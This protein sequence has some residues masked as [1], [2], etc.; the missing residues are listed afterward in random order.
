M[1]YVY[2]LRP[3]GQAGPIKIGFTSDVKKR[4]SDYARWSPQPLEVAAAIPGDQRLER[5]FHTAF[6]DQRLHHEW[7]DASDDLASAI[8]QISRGAFDVAAL[9]APARTGS[10]MSPEGAKAARAAALLYA[11]GRRGVCIPQEVIEAKNAY[12]CTPEE[13]ARR[14]ALVAAFVEAHSASGVAA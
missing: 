9:P 6:A 3:V 2:F 1:G 10:S 12:G 8:E 13:T 4:L 5:R 11:I 14:R 7:F